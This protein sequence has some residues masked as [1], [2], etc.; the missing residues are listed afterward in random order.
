MLIGWYSA[1]AVSRGRRGFRGRRGG[2]GRPADRRCRSLPQ[3]SRGAGRVWRPPLAAGP[4]VGAGGR[5]SSHRA[6]PRIPF[7]SVDT[8]CLETICVGRRAQDA[9]FKSGHNRTPDGEMVLV[10]RIDAPDGS[11]LSKLGTEEHEYLAPTTCS[12]PASESPGRVATLRSR[13]GCTLYA[14]ARDCLVDERQR[15]WQMSD[16]F[17]PPCSV[18]QASLLGLWTR[19]GQVLVSHCY[20]VYILA[21]AIRFAVLDK[22]F[23]RILPES[24]EICMPGALLAADLRGARRPRGPPRAARAAVGG[25]AHTSPSCVRVIGAAAGTSL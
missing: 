5:G 18:P 13:S 4:A 7:R 16:S 12:G 25:W 8:R 6:I 11:G 2:C 17:C 20:I 9:P 22:G 14:R 3:T 15:W 21:N 23:L 10:T 24:R 1:P 19:A